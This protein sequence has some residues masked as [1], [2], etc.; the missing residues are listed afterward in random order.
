[1]DLNLSN[2]ITPFYTGFLSLIYTGLAFWVIYYRRKF[3]QGIGDGG[4]K[5]LKRIIRVHGNFIEYVPLSLILILFAELSGM[6]SLHLHIAG[7]CLVLGRLLHAFG[8]SKSVGTSPGRFI[9]MCLNFS[10]IIYLG[11]YLM[12]KYLTI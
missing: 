9:G 12:V 7:T 11:I 8:L 3:A 10:L 6:K 5:E 1:M 2:L 4:H